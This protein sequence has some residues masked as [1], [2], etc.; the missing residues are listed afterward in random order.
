[1]RDTLAG[2]DK[3]NHI[4]LPISQPGEGFGEKVI[5]LDSELCKKLELFAREIRSTQTTLLQ[6]AWGSLISRLTGDPDVVFGNVVS[7]RPPA[8]TRDRKH[9]RYVHLCRA[10][11]P[12]NR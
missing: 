11:T 8:N 7:G 2:F 6:A 12:A 3:P 10:G 9:D 4:D 1:M 5:Y